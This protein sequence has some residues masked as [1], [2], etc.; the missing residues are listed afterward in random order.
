VLWELWSDLMR[1]SHKQCLLHLC[2]CWDMCSYSTLIGL[3]T[4]RWGTRSLLFANV[5]DHIAI[6]SPQ[7]AWRKGN[8]SPYAYT[9]T[10]IPPPFWWLPLPPPLANSSHFS[11]RSINGTILSVWGAEI[12]QEHNHRERGCSMG[13]D[14]LLTRGAS[15]CV[16]HL[17]NAKDDSLGIRPIGR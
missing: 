5:W 10:N 2:A 17:R 3:S 6:G 7:G 4:C 1:L 16:I 9:C 13:L 15:V 8:P 12:L 14:T 11:G